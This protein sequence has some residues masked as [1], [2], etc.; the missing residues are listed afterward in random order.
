MGSPAK[1]PG[2]PLEA[3]RFQM[4]DAAEDARYI[5]SVRD[6]PNN[7]FAADD[8]EVVLDEWGDDYDD[9]ADDSDDSGSDSMPIG[10]ARRLSRPQQLD[11]S[12][13]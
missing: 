3:T 8:A 13:H 11:F 2:T 10:H 9:K 5:A 12:A 1:P 4:Q 7:A 6:H